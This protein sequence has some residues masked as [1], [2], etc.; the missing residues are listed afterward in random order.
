MKIVLI[1]S[2]LLGLSAFAND[3][4]VQPTPS[5]NGKKPGGNQVTDDIQGTIV[6]SSPDKEKQ[7]EENKKV[8]EDHLK[9]QPKG[10]AKGHA[11]K[12]AKPAKK[13]KSKA[14]KK[15]KQ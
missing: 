8:H 4:V 3:N 7:L 14:K 12:A 5:D 2:L 1:L 11:K 6:P 15:S 10:K 13:A 9:S